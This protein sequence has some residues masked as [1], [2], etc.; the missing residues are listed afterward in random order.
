MYKFIFMFFRSLIKISQNKNCSISSLESFVYMRGGEKGKSART[1]RECCEI[2]AHNFYDVVSM[3]IRKFFQ[4]LCDDFKQE[5]KI[6]TENSNLKLK[7]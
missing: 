6:L 1:G 7:I 5:F 4:E 3:T 2:L